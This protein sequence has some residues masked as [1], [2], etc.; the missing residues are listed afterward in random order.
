MHFMRDKGGDK[1]TGAYT[2]QIEPLLEEKQFD[3]I[4]RK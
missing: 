4:G 3:D 1:D 2:W